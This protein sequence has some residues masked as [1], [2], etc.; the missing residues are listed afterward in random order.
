MSVETEP[1]FRNRHVRNVAAGMLGLMGVAGIAYGLGT[2]TVHKDPPYLADE[3]VQV[4]VFTPASQR[5]AVG[6]S[7]IKAVHDVV[8]QLAS[9]VPDGKKYNRIVAIGSASDNVGDNVCAGGR[10]NKVL[11]QRRAERVEE[12]LR[13]QFGN[14]IEIDTV[15]EYQD[16]TPSQCGAVRKAVARYNGLSGALASSD[17]R[18]ADYEVL[19][20]NIINRRYVGA[21]G[22][23]AAPE[24]T[25]QEYQRLAVNYSLVIAGGLMLL[26]AGGI[27]VSG[28]RKQG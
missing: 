20:E 4:K 23:V 10:G 5:F 14:E 16:L 22:Y 13:D 2:D 7:D 6:D 11:S 17:V 15:S 8:G 27:A 25:A 28:G 12:E 1:R 19:S 9:H 26:G 21:I 24:S 18:T 3:T